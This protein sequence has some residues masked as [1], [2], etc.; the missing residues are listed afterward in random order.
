MKDS[1]DIPMGSTEE[2][3]FDFSGDG[4]KEGDYVLTIT[5]AVSEE[6]DNGTQHK[7]TF[8]GEGLPF[9]VPVNYWTQHNNPR[10]Q[11]A[12]RGNLKK[13]A[14]AALGQ[15]KYTLAT[16]KGTKVL[17]RVGE[18]KE[19]FVRVT[20]FRKVPAAVSAAAI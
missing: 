19:G 16:I 8:E 12:G 17:A 10:A 20:N 5:D 13:I 7:L 14:T 3:T 2:E 4:I 9:P 15:P 6:K 11:N 18:D 1:M